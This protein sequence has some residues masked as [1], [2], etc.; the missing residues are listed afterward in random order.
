MT[1]AEYIRP[2]QANKRFFFAVELKRTKKNKV[3]YEIRHAL[4][5]NFD[6]RYHEFNFDPSL[7]QFER[8][9]GSTET[10]P[11]LKKV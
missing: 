10:I 9:F 7:Y 1:S 4:L 2:Q 5:N 3:L 8:W 6:P 11:L